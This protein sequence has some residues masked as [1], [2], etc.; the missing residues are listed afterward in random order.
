M[1][2]SE[3][4]PWQ[5][6]YSSPGEAIDAMLKWRPEIPTSDRPGGFAVAHVPGE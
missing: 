4:A 6:V 1:S 5:R 2:E 3:L